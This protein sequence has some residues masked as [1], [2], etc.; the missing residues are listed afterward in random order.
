MGHKGTLKLETDRLK[1]RRFCA[2][3]AL[4]AFNNWCSEDKVTKYLRLPTH[5]NIAAIEEII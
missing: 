2:E 5:P 1:L 4:P 3:D